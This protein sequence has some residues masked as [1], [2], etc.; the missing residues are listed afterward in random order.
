MTKTLEGIEVIEKPEPA[1]RRR[2][3][4]EDKRQLLARSIRA[5]YS[6]SLVARCNGVSSSLSFRC[7]RL[8]ETG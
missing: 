4:A 2:F 5:G 8:M 1:K 7:R 3:T 6:I